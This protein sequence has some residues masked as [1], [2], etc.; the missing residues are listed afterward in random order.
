MTD[1]PNVP[2]QP[3][4]AEPAATEP[5]ETAAS[6]AP[7]AGPSAGEAWDEVVLRLREMGLGEDQMIK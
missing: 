3:E 5:A 2:I 7:P 1:D 6:E 4:P